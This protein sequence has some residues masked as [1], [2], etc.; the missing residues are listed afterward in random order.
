MHAAPELIY[1]VLARMS[2]S[3]AACGA[4]QQQQVT[5]KGSAH[6]NSAENSVSNVAQHESEALL[7]E[8]NGHRRCD[9]SW[10]GLRATLLITTACAAIGILICC[11][12][13]ATI[14]DIVEAALL[15]W[16]QRLLHHARETVGDHKLRWT[17]C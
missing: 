17:L 11:C 6:G 8:L 1:N 14:A 16:I 7:E 13:P 5:V 4:S 9:F 10:R 2:R 3:I 15:D 12:P